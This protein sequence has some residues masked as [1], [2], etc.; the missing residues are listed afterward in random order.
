MLCSEVVSSKTEKPI[1]EACNFIMK[2]NKDLLSGCH[3]PIRTDDDS[4]NL[5][6]LSFFH[7]HCNGSRNKVKLPEG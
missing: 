4:L 5:G 7:N 6:S 1:A 3:L 2:Q